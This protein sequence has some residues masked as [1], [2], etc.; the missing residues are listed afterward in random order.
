MRPYPLFDTYQKHPWP[1]KGYGKVLISSDR[2]LCGH[3]KIQKKYE[4]E[5]STVDDCYEL[6]LTFNGYGGILLRIFTP[7][8]FFLCAFNDFQCIITLLRALYVVLY[9]TYS[10]INT[11]ARELA[12]LVMWLT[13]PNLF[14]N[15]ATS[16]AVSAWIGDPPIRYIWWQRS[17]SGHPRDRFPSQKMHLWMISSG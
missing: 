8:L 11:L 6:F 15:K 1:P 17:D 16:I 7:Y 9:V 2:I 4:L 13:R 12:F 3:R 5:V 14:R 10:E